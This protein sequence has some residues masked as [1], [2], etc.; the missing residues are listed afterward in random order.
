M[1]NVQMEEHM[2]QIWKWIIVIPIVVGIIVAVSITVKNQAAKLDEQS[3]LE[4]VFGSLAGKTA[5]ITKFYTYGTSFNVE[6]KIKAISKDNFEGIKL[7]VT[8][9]GEFEKTYKLSYSFEDNH[10]IFSTGDTMND[11]INLDE[12]PF[13]KY[14]VQ[15]RLKAN[16]SKDYKYYTLSNISEY[17]NIE[18]YTLTKEEKN[19]RIDIK[20]DK[21]KWNDKEYSYLGLT[22]EESKLPDDVYDIVIDSGNGGT[23]SGESN[24]GT[25]ES[26]LMLEYGKALKEVLETKGYKVKLTRDDNNTDSFTSTNMYDSN[27]RITIACKTKAKYMISLHTGENGFSGIQIFT[28]NSVNFSLAENLANNLYNSSSLEFSS[29]KSWKKQDGVYQRTFTNA[30]IRERNS[31]LEKQGIEPYN[32]TTNTPYLYTIREVGGIA[33]NAYVDGRNPSYS[34]NQYYNSNQ[35]IECYQ[36]S[37]G[38]LKY[39]KDILLSEKEQIVNAIANAF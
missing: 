26:N 5:E 38:S 30:E 37:I 21:E 22:V 17:K 8:D 10:I 2:K 32:I 34:A 27:G 29:N 20:F 7:L 12:L 18:Y 11:A 6:G 3:R 1:F 15:V 23:D 16:N 14:Y 19:N 4:K 35:G 24:A 25:T 13:G 36:I 39:D 9:G 28:P 31:T 33:T